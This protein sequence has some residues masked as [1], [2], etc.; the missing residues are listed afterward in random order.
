[1]LGGYQ[2]SH[3]EPPPDTPIEAYVRLVQCL[4]NGKSLAETH[5]SVSL[6]REV[7][8]RAQKEVPGLKVRVIDTVGTR[9][10]LLLYVIPGTGVKDALAPKQED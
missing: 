6:Y 5:L 9:T 2:V 3:D 4:L 7:I 1:M 10:H 8:A